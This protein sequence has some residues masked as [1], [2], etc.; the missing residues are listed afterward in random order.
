MAHTGS[1]TGSPRDH[2]ADSDPTLSRKRARLSED[3]HSPGSDSQRGEPHIEAL[4]PDEP[5]G[6]SFV[7][8]IQIGDGDEYDNMEPYSATFRIWPDYTPLAQLRHIR[9]QIA[10][11]YCLE[12]G[13]LTDLCA[14]V[15]GHMSDTEGHGKHQLL[16]AYTQDND[17]FGELALLA[18]G[19]LDRMEWLDPEFNHFA[20]K[21]VICD[22][23][24]D[25]VALAARFVLLLPCITKEKLA[26]RDSMQHRSN[27]H[28]EIPTLRYINVAASLVCGSAPCLRYLRTECNFDKGCAMAQWRT[29]F[30]RDTLRSLLET[31][32]DV[33]Y[34]ARE[35]KQSW[36]ILDA[37]LKM[38]RRLVH[39]GEGATEV[40]A[41]VKE[42]ILPLIQEKHPRALPI[43]FHANVVVTTAAL[44]KNCTGQADLSRGFELYERFVKND[45]DALLSCMPSGVPPSQALALTCGEDEHTLAEL[46]SASW[47]LQ[48]YKAFIFSTIM[49]VRSC[50]IM[51]LCRTLE[52]W[53][54]LWR[55]AADD[56]TNKSVT[57]YAA[58]FLRV[59]DLTSYIFSADSH[60][61]IVSHSKDI[62]AFLA[63]TLTYTDHETDT[64]WQACTTS[65]EA[66]FAKAS[67]DVLEYLTHYLG[68]DQL[69]YIAQ[70]FTSAPI[71]VL[72]AERP[73]GTL[74]MLFRRFLEVCPIDKQ[75]LCSQDAAGLA[76]EI[77]RRLHS[78]DTLPLAR[79][80]WKVAMTEIARL[81]DMNTDDRLPLYERC[82]PD[83][84]EHTERATCSYEILSLFLNGWKSDPEAECLLA[85]LPPA[86][87]VDEIGHYMQQIA[88]VRDMDC[89]VRMS[90]IIVRLDS[91]VWL[92]SLG[93]YSRDSD[94]EE[95]LFDY[96]L[97]DMAPNNSVRQTAWSRLASLRTMEPAFAAASPLISHYLD[98]RVPTLSASQVT[99]SLINLMVPP[100]EDTLRTDSHQD[101]PPRL[102]QSPS[103]KTLVRAATY[104]Q[105]GYTAPYATNAI[106][107]ILFVCPQD[108]A[109]KAAVVLCHA[110]FVRYFVEQM[111]TEY[112]ERMRLGDGGEAQQLCRAVS[113]L[114]A[115]LDRS[116]EMQDFYRTPTRP[117]VCS[118]TKEKTE[119][120]IM[121][122]TGQIYRPNKGNEIIHIQT[123]KTNTVAQLA[124]ALPS[125][126]DGSQ[127]RIM[128][129]G[130]RL[131]LEHDGPKPLH[132][133]VGQAGVIMVCPKYTADTDLDKVLPSPG[134]IEREIMALYDRIDS[135]LDGPPLAAKS[136]FELLLK[137]R[138]S[139]SA[140]SR[141]ASA[142]ATA[143]ELFPPARPWRTLFSSHV[144]RKHLQDFA[145]LA[146]ADAS[147]I[148]RTVRLYCDYITDDSRPFESQL[149][150]TILADLV[151][152]MQ[153]RSTSEEPF[154]PPRILA[155]D[156]KPER[157]S[158][159]GSL[160]LFEDPDK[161]VRRLCDLL[162]LVAPL[163]SLPSRASLSL[164]IYET[165]LESMRSDDRV[166]SSV[167][168]FDDGAI[169][170]LH[171]Q[172]LLD[173]DLTLTT[174]LADMIANYCRDSSSPADAQG[175]YWRLVSRTIPKAFAQPFATSAFFKLAMD[176]LTTSRALQKDEAEVR[177]IV[178]SLT[179]TLWQY[180][181]SEAPVL[182]L[183]DHAVLG[184]LK[185]VHSAILLLKSFNKPLDCSHLSVA[186]MRRLLFPPR[187]DPSAPLLTDDSRDIAFDIVRATCESAGDFAT[188]AQITGDAM[189]ILTAEPM[190]VFCH[191][192][193]IKPPAQCA[194]L[195]N[196]G[197]TCYM[198]SLLQQ[199][200]ANLA[201]RELV[202]DTP[203][204]DVER[205]LF[206]SSLQDLF[207]QMQDANVHAVDT[208]PLA[209]VL[210]IQTDSQEDVHGFYA[211]FLSRLEDC[212]I[213]Q[214]GK[215]ALNKLFAG[216]FKS[217][218]KGECG[219]VSTQT[220]SFNDVSITVKNKAS[221]QE[222]LAE[223][224]QGEPMRGANRYRCM[225][226]DPTDGGRLVN[227]TKRTALDRVPNNLTFCLKRFTFEAM[228]GA[229][230][231]VN[232]AFQFPPQIDM[233]VFETE[234]LEQP[235]T[236]VAPDIF[237]L[238]GVIVH[239][240]S[241]QFG[242]YWSYVRL[243]GPTAGNGA[244][245]WVQLE[246]KHAR[247]CPGGIGEIQEQCF[248]GLFF[249]NGQERTDNAYVL[250]YQR[251]QHLHEQAELA[252]PF[253]TDL[254]LEI[255]TLLLP[256][257]APPPEMARRVLTLSL[258]RHRIDQFYNPQFNRFVRWLL[259][260]MSESPE[261][262]DE[263]ARFMSTYLLRVVLCKPASLE[264]E[265]GPL[266]AYLSRRL[267]G[268]QGSFAKYMLSHLISVP[269]VFGS[270]W[271]H[272]TPNV[273]REMSDF[274][275][276]CISTLRES[277]RECYYETT[278]AVVVAHASV[279]QNYLD[280]Q[281]ALWSDYLRFVAAV[282]RIG[283]R[284]TVMVLDHDYV[285]WAFEITFLEYDSKWAAKHPVPAK[286]TRANR[287]ELS[288]LFDFVSN[289]LAEHVDLEADPTAPHENHQLSD[290]DLVILNEPEHRYLYYEL[291]LDKKQTWLLGFVGSQR[292]ATTTDW[293]SFAPGKLLRLLTSQKAT[294]EHAVMVDRML[295]SRLEYEQ[296]DLPPLLHMMLH[297]CASAVDEDMVITFRELAKCL[298]LWNE[299]PA[300]LDFYKIAFRLKPMATIESI[301]YFAPSFLLLSK[302]PH[303]RRRTLEW[304]VEHAFVDANPNSPYVTARARGARALAKKCLPHL[305]REYS[306][307]QPRR[308]YE[309]AMRAMEMALSFLTTIHDEWQTI[310][311]NVTRD[312]HER[313]APDHCIEYE[314]S[315]PAIKSLREVLEELA[316]WTSEMADAEAIVGP[317]LSLRAFRADADVAENSDGEAGDTEIE[318]E[319]SDDSGRT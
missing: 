119:R 191:D 113:V 29:R 197:M 39:D 31:F 181:H 145:T 273:R 7:S 98:A 87:V 17:F 296:H 283:P 167:A 316:D 168:A 45:G 275:L 35:V 88:Q 46:L 92:M 250:F 104:S 318:E 303:D 90:T 133:V 83:I 162:G 8:A 50:G 130:R 154:A 223:F 266:L 100:L 310:L 227:A 146:V 170:N 85:M 55:K 214:A 173:N 156:L 271:R 238:V 117:A 204:V 188:L 161:L 112:A 278:R 28:H 58:R 171:A 193:W 68:F 231:K 293:E 179:S 255:A 201:F 47:V 78:E 297:Y 268:N 267:A 20:L 140:R 60:A 178:A 77:V 65:V 118:L 44:L 244:G 308:R 2:D 27:P 314:E 187:D 300:C 269:V 142:N 276:A 210:D 194:G 135:F 211:I 292:C 232:D 263:I 105:D 61:S 304:M 6:T 56:S 121:C 23:L 62:I 319:F 169:S 284:E 1:A 63:A 36:S 15:R 258:D 196:L 242:H 138:P 301:P 73:A 40:L 75:R 277:K 312:D 149:L 203:V 160:D 108:F 299:V 202:F 144:L 274:I 241:L 131:S 272:H 313:L 107:H 54:S 18:H 132:E 129:G 134:P 228:M 309:P 153:G 166:W 126:V 235:G 124:A 110:E 192:E 279:R 33:S 251:K 226:C 94:V 16:Q 9:D 175:F 218:V 69:F 80:T 262:D 206:L 41:T 82:V 76:F 220:E 215:E 217:Q 93:P 99:Q 311:R 155:S 307:E 125:H 302:S 243:R 128:V 120:D 165:L 289:V 216:T 53:H 200:F 199:M 42:A 24:D 147:F 164:K 195:Y 157:S 225:T 281:P 270:I 151:Q 139:A 180:R 245:T 247:P 185:L 224:V 48:A 71:A 254:P 37:A 257:V 209:K 186:L 59:N 96:F 67:F 260:S 84:V 95:R 158:D 285:L 286:M 163:S 106:C 12:P 19:L 14:W 86:A 51:L 221:L 11:D 159:Y 256:R 265:L 3:E 176:L 49:D 306:A 5:I 4:V 97:G 172:L 81:A 127:S 70:K 64:I 38:M 198:N 295:L 10:S 22:L 237:E 150:L 26:R 184:L 52:Q 182:P 111:C 177:S 190:Q 208:A 21:A 222:S 141:V 183:V 102:L 280:N 213:D 34:S 291:T 207:T 230:G 290:D 89:D 115:V 248:G 261:V 249:A 74:S 288:P 109:H 287:L 233:S 252:T 264:K 234:H 66:D 205:Q 315:K 116:R 240:G 143:N 103:W 305:L 152:F 174:G 114:T 294:T 253:P 148:T 79:S 236:P 43:E 25:L 219:H 123:D 122:F 13:W 317:S 101:S 282:A 189:Q 239:Q 72:T 246:D 137:L 212:M 57:E 136:A 32:H 298:T 91:A 259:E 229:E 30:D